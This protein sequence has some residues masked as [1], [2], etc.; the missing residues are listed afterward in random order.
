[1]TSAQTQCGHRREAQALLACPIHHTALEESGEGFVCATC[2]EVGRRN[3]VVA[4]FVTT[5]DPF[6]EGRYDNRTKYLPKDDGFWATLPLRIVLQG[7]PTAVAAAAPAGATVVEL[8]CAGGVAWFGRRYQMIGV[9]LS[10]GALPRA[11]ENYA[12]V[13]QAD[14]TRLPLR[15]HCADAI[16]SSCF[17]EHFD[18]AGKRALLQECRRVLKPGGAVVF[19]YDIWTEHPIIAAFRRR[20]PQR[21][22]AEFLDQDGHIGYCSINSNGALFRE[23]GFTIVRQSYHERTPLLANSS[24]QKLAHWPGLSGALARMGAAATSGPFLYPA[25]AA[26]AAADTTI[27]R[28]LPRSHARC[29][30]TT[31]R[32]L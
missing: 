23:A 1:M 10:A 4:S 12:M 31:A 13:V 22:A 32:L 15:A 8:G 26:I 27:G 16:V 25:L 28:F 7:Y 14:A 5:P 18:D 6:Y 21:Y 17:F 20:D 30:L 19:Y 29:V 3:G 24:W 11:A 2:G 9:D